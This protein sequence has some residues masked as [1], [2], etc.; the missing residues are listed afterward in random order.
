MHKDNFLCLKPIF[1]LLVWFCIFCSHLPTAK[2][3][4]NQTA[5][6]KALCDWLSKATTAKPDSAKQAID[7]LVAQGADINCHCQITKSYTNYLRVLGNGIK[8][9]LA[10]F[11]LNRRQGTHDGETYTAQEFYTP[12]HLWVIAENKPLITYITT[13]YKADLN[14]AAQVS[15]QKIYPL[16]EVVKANKLDY[17]QW[18][19]KLGAST[20]QIKLC[21]PSLPMY[22][23]L[24]EAG[25]NINNTDWSCLSYHSETVLQSILEKYKPDLTQSKYTNSKSWQGNYSPKTLEL[26]LQCG[27]KPDTEM[28]DYYFTFQSQNI[29]AYARLFD[30]YG[31]DFSTCGFFNCPMSCAI[32]ENNLEMVKLFANKGVLTVKKPICTDN[33]AILDE[34]V[35]KGFPTSNIDISCLLNKPEVLEIVLKKHKPNLNLLLQ[36]SNFDDISLKSLELLAAAGFKP[37]ENMIIALL[38]NEIKLKQMV[39]SYQLNL[40]F[41]SGNQELTKASHSTLDY[42]FGLGIEPAKDLLSYKLK[43]S[44]KET[45]NFKLLQTYIK[46]KKSLDD[47]DF[48][49]CPLEIIIQNDDLQSL[50]LMAENGAALHQQF[51]GGQTPLQYAESLHRIAMVNY[52][53]TKLK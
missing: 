50:K 9:A 37:S 46:H 34:L 10:S 22:D 19:V 25:A 42:L 1:C 53:K 21:A 2:A 12:V 23:W 31:L 48:F 16:E 28:M 15:S 3:Q 24:I 13:K 49:G 52:L 43:F 4:T 47:C 39:N 7:F 41:L 33:I 38:D 20:T 44:I 27:I 6:D 18:L 40:N 11:F 45:D 51:K 29:M 35:G 30:K 17:A 26:V 36:K 8:N 14:K 32:K 5:A